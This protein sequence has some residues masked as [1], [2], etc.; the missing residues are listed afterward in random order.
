MAW[1]DPQQHSD[2]ALVGVQDYVGQCLSFLAWS[3]IVRG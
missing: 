2:R 1:Y 3:L